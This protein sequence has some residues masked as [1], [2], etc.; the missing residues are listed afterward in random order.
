MFRKEI[1]ETVD[2]S[3]IPSALGIMLKFAN[4]HG[5]ELEEDAKKMV[6]A[7]FE[8][9][10]QLN[11]ELIKNVK[12]QPDSLKKRQTLRL[13]RKSKGSHFDVVDLLAQIEKAPNLS[14]DIIKEGR[15]LFIFMSQIAYNYLCDVT[16]QS[17]KG[18]GQQIPFISLFYNALD[19]A[20]VSFHLAS[21][22]FATQSMSHT[23]NIIEAMDL[24]EL[25]QKDPEYI[26]FWASD[27]YKERNK[28]SPRE[29]R[30]LLKKDSLEED[31]YWILSDFGSHA[32]FKSIQTKTAIK[33]DGGERKAEIKINVGGVGDEFHTQQAIV[34]CLTT[35]MKLVARISNFYEKILLDEELKI[36]LNQINERFM[37]FM[38]NK[39]SYPNIPKSF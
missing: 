33:V 21:H 14:K 39:T 17:L 18:G 15:E 38:K 8:L 22:S 11:D 28:V 26:K 4:E 3:K 29:V 37:N 35:L 32:T 12:T 23:R 31:V 27:D 10:D 16:E 30:K 36:D 20:L 34:A 24:I 7:Q 1:G 2:V 13:S 5:D 25:F 19:E 6:D 9:V